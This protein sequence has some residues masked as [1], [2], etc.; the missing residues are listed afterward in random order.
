MNK[1]PDPE[2][3]SWLSNTI[4][5]NSE[6]K[7]GENR[8][9]LG[10]ETWQRPRIALWDLQS[11]KKLYNF[12]RELWIF[13]FHYVKNYVKNILLILHRDLLM[14]QKRNTRESPWKAFINTACPRR[15]RG[16]KNSRTPPSLIKRLLL[17]IVSILGNIIHSVNAGGL[18][19]IEKVDDSPTSHRFNTIDYSSRS[20]RL[21]YIWLSKDDLNILIVSWVIRFEFPTFSHS[22]FLYVVRKFILYIRLLIE[23][24]GELQPPLGL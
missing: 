19:P 4:F 10:K 8:G 18:D 17:K 1:I 20:K 3:W 23:V 14:C 24:V 15:W 7:I 12:M 5:T 2:S 13:C 22:K 21:F 11:Y 16:T 9:L 6:M